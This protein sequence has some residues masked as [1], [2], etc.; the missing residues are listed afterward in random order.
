MNVRF[1]LRLDKV[2][3]NGEVPI[4]VNVN[5]K[6][7]QKYIGESCLEKDFLPIEKHSNG[8]YVKGDPNLNDRL[9]YIESEVL[10]KAR[11]LRRQ[12]II[13]SP[14][15]LENILR[16][17]IIVNTPETTIADLLARWKARNKNNTSANGYRRFDQFLN[18]LEVYHTGLTANEIDEKFIEEY[19]EYLIENIPTIQSNNT[20]GRHIKFFKMILKEAGLNS[21]WI[22]DNYTYDSDKPFLHYDELMTFYKFNYSTDELREKAD[23]G[24]FMGFTGLRHSDATK[25]SKSDLLQD[26]EGAYLQLRQVKTKKPVRMY[27]NKYALEIIN[28]YEGKDKLQLVP[29][30][31]NSDMNVDLKVCAKSCGLEREVNKILY[32]GN[33]RLSIVEPLHKTIGCHTFRHTFATISLNNG[34]PSEVLAEL[35]GITLNTV[36]VYAKLLNKTKADFVNKVWG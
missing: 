18:H 36:S 6:A 19:V 29:V 27:L 26:K 3:K 4:Y 1:F 11:E 10:E 25:V 13:F 14:V 23:A 24:S 2:K 7:I 8:K 9:A 35:M 16:P 33:Q 15:D 20:I 5:G 30:T 21:D 17:P 28:K 34:M 12:G 31:S 32:R 22:K